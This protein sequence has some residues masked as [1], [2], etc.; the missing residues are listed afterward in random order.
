[1]RP[2]FLPPPEPIPQHEMRWDVQVDFDILTP[3]VPMHSLHT[4]LH[5]GAMPELVP[6]DDYGMLLPYSNALVFDDGSLRTAMYGFVTVDGVVVTDL[7][8]DGIVMAANPHHWNFYEDRKEYP[9]YMLTINTPESEWM[10]PYGRVKIAVSATDGSWIT[11]FDYINVVFTEDVIL[12]YRFHPAV[13][14]VDVIDYNG[15]HLYNMLDADWA[16]GVRSAPGERPLINEYFISIQQFNEKVVLVDVRTGEALYLDLYDI[17]SFYEGYAAAAFEKTDEGGYSYLWGFVDTDFQEVIP[18]QYISPSVF[19]HGMAIVTLPD[20][21]EQVINTHGEALFDVPDGYRFRYD[22]ELSVFILYPET[23]DR[24]PIV[25][26]YDFEEVIPP[27]DLSPDN[28]I[29]MYYLGNGW[30]TASPQLISDFL[31]EKY[32]LLVNGNE[33][34]SFPGIDFI[35]FTDGDFIIH[36]QIDVRNVSH[37][38]VMTLDRQIILSPEPNIHITPVMKDGKANGFI[39][40]SRET[41]YMRDPQF[42]PSTYRLIDTTGKTVIQGSGRLT[43]HDSFELYSIQSANHFTWLDKD[44]KPMIVIPLM[45]S[46]FD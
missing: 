11:P 17:H 30:H 9:A 19:Q 20:W 15:I 37:D 31:S 4:R 10:Y 16:E 42:I 39:L 36:S 18:G 2:P 28:F 41:W 23:G 24:T 7:I 1:M 29:S 35:R 33:V 32:S 14:D 34:H 5:D 45:S 22:Y 44:A 25:L 8:Y 13:L 40:N 46:T 3:F 26:S 27:A 38:G 21:S 6:S 43:Y 12:L